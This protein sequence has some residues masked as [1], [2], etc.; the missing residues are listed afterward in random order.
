MNSFG[1]PTLVPAEL[2]P[3]VRHS[4]TS[5]SR[6]SRRR[7]HFSR[8]VAASRMPPQLYSQHPRPPPLICHRLRSL[9]SLR[10]LRGLRR[11]RRL[12]TLRS[13]RLRT[14]RSLRRLRSLPDLHRWA[15][16]FDLV[17]MKFT[18]SHRRELPWN[19][20]V[21][22]SGTS[23]CSSYSISPRTSR[24]CGRPCSRPCSR[25]DTCGRP[26]SRLSCRLSHSR[27]FAR[28]ADGGTVPPR[29]PSRSRSLSASPFLR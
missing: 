13:C 6:T 21:V 9:R 19:G 1:T 2:P 7:S 15:A 17:G 20:A 26:C 25:N 28:S 4:L 29:R 11:L 16:V 12:R 23:R 18:T 14:L 8:L 3:R 5:G 22:S 24:P 10:S 27:F